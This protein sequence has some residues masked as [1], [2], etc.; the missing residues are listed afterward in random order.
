MTQDTAKTITIAP[1]EIII[2]FIDLLERARGRP[3][4]YIGVVEPYWLHTLLWGIE[5]ALKWCGIEQG[6]GLYD[7]VE[8]ER[9]WKNDTAL[10]SLPHMRDAGLT[11]KQIVDENLIIAAEI[12]KRTL[13]ELIGNQEALVALEEMDCARHLHGATNFS[14]NRSDQFVELPDTI[15]QQPAEYTIRMYP[16]A[17][18][19]LTELPDTVQESLRDTIRSLGDN[20]HPPASH[21]LRESDGW[22]LPVS[23]HRIVYQIDDTE[24]YVTVW[25]VGLQHHK[26]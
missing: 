10:G 5:T 14:L 4:M 22:R 15:T 21:K 20:P 3:G 8:H 16:W 17:H 1:Q 24:K 13:I 9:G 26:K 7:E 18:K 19:A 23:D 12:W 25:N 2:Q 11:D 6:D